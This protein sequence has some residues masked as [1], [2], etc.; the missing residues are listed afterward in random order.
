K[1]QTEVDAVCGRERVPHFGDREHLPYL[2]ALIKEVTRMRPSVPSDIPHTT[3]EDD[4]HDGY[5][6]PKGT[7]FKRF[8]GPNPEQD[9]YEI[10]FGFGRRLC[11]GC[12]FADASLYI[13]MT[14]S[15]SAF[16]VSLA[17]DDAGKPIIPERLP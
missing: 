16:D 5:Y 9:P 13:T 12:L 3:T 14:M 7:I 1:A 6:I 11:P 2:E 4:V 17:K 15:L 10:I 8:L